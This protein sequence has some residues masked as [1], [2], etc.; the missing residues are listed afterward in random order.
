MSSLEAALSLLW[1]TTLSFSFGLLTVAC[2]RRPVRRRFG[3]GSAYLLWVLPLLAV[4]VSLLPHPI[5]MRSQPLPP[6]VLTVVAGDAIA[7]MPG[8]SSDRLLI[9]GLMSVWMLGV[10]LS[11]S[12][13]IARQRR[14]QL[15]LRTARPFSGASLAWPVWLARDDAT[16]PAM[17]GAWRPFIV[18]P[19]DFEKR[20]DESERVLILAHEA[21]HIRRRDGWWCAVAQV[22]AC[23]FWFHPLLWWALPAWRHDQELACDAA[24]IREH[25]GQRRRYALAMLKTQAV[26]TVLPMGCAWSPRHPLTER[27]AMLHSS[28]IYTVKRLSGISTIA[29]AALLASAAVYAGTSIAGI[30]SPRDQRYSLKLEVAVNGQP[31]KVHAA[32]CLAVGQRYELIED[33][34]PNLAPWRA[35]VGVVPTDKGQLEVRADIS[36]GTLNG[37]TQP[38]IRVSEGQEGTIMVGSRLGP[39]AG[40]PVGEHTLTLRALPSTGC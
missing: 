33:S 25:A 1:L 39:S 22:C 37:T 4:L 12:L 14:F 24:V 40:V 26:A 11:A 38:R 27:I 17:V 8:A 16:G 5:H 28:Q 32:T 3:A 23:L 36:G 13:A 18:L 7:E 29:L 35:L 10:V 31:A 9:V 6:M 2:L 20:Y 19:R 21:M 30:A 15:A 34:T